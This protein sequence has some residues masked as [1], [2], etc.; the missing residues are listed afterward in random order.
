[1][2]KIDRI[3][4]D[5]YE[6]DDLGIYKGQIYEKNGEYYTANYIYL[7]RGEKSGFNEVEPYEV[8]GK[9][10]CMYNEIFF[11]Y[12]AMLLCNDIVK[13]DKFLYD[14]IVNGD[15]DIEVYEYYLI[16]DRTAQFLKE[17]TN[18]LIFYS[19]KLD[20]YV[21]GV[22]YDTDCYDVCTTIEL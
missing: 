14:N 4:K 11:D 19:E 17:H 20:L 16:D 12:S 15:I 13:V 2:N 18:E 22:T 8:H 3:S 1:M 6:V 10:H 5:I 7:L 21:L 9:L